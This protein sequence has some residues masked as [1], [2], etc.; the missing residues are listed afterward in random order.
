MAGKVWA[1]A[2]NAFRETVRQPVFCVLLGIALATIALSPSFAMFT[3]FDDVKLV[4]DMGLSTILLAGLLLAVLSASNVVTEEVRGRTAL[5]VV[6]RPV[7]RGAFVLGKFLGILG[8]QAAAAYLLSLVLVLTVRIGVPEAVYTKLDTPLIWG[9]MAAVLL[10]LGAATAAN[11]FFD[12]PF[13]SAVIFA[14]LGIFSLLFFGSAFFDRELNL[15]PYLEAMDIETLK[16]CVTLFPMLAVLTAAAVACA[17]RL[18]LVVSMFVCVV[19]F[20]VG[21]LSE[22]L[23]E[24]LAA[25]SRLVAALPAVV[26]PSFQVFWMGDAL[27]AGSPIPWD[28]IGTAMAYGA[29]YCTAL[30]F[31]GMSL[32]EAREIQ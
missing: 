27:T 14:A 7:G 21:T 24:Q 18:T 19:F 25:A 13:P 2:S 32:F 9:E 1:I 11:Y 31:L 20:A 5:M 28:Y 3:I 10:T 26:L 15:V 4:K 16:A 6:A 17:T 29:L 8:A 23:F 22:Y 30:V 12:R